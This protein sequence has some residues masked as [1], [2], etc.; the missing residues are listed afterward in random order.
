MSELS[1][2]IPL[3]PMDQKTFSGP[4]QMLKAA[5]PYLSPSTGQTF[6]LL[7][8]IL[9][10]KYT[11]NIFQDN[12]LSICSLSNNKRPDFEQVLKD[13]KKYCAS[14]EAEQIDQFLNIIQAMRLYNQYNELLNNSEFSNIINQMST[15]NSMKNR[16][17]NISPDQIQMIQNMFRSHE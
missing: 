5:I 15:M 4:I 6:A 10:L 9:E 2:P 12:Q 8:R 14:S 13:I 3:T 17:I 1:N 16:N 7:A 11:M